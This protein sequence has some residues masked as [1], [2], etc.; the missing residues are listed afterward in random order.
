[1]KLSFRSGRASLL[2]IKVLSLL[3]SILLGTSLA[4]A[5]G[6]PTD[7]EKEAV[8]KESTEISS[9]VKDE[10]V[11]EQSAD[12][13][14][15]STGAVREMPE[16]KK[17]A[18]GRFTVGV[19]GSLSLLSSANTSAPSVN[20]M[21]SQYDPFDGTVDFTEGFSLN[22]ALGYALG[23]GLRLEA[24]GGYALESCF[25][26]MDVKMPGTLQLLNVPTGK[27][28]M[29]GKLSAATLMLNAYYDLDLSDNLMPYL[30]GGL[31]MAH[32]SANPKLG[33]GAESG[34]VLVDDE[35]YVFVYQLGTGL[36]YR[37]S[38]GLIGGSDLTIT[39]DYRYLASFED[40]KF[41]GALTG[42]SVESEFG[43]HY[44]GGGIRLGLW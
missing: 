38:N 12:V 32:I 19:R 23:N 36:G 14:E 28:K 17:E 26:E 16:A 34:R 8:V 24:E 35:D 7:V 42:S 15:S 11:T 43:G 18:V 22:L 6:G 29:G 41:K 39:L 1:M 20:F 2:S 31:G 4:L 37:I 10:A 44:I 13:G 40:L 9:E 27:T 5:G 25:K 3:F 30:G 33:E 21:N